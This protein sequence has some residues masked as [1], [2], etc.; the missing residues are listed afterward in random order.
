[1]HADVDP[2]HVKKC[3]GS[4]KE[5]IKSIN[6]KHEKLNYTRDDVLEKELQLVASCSYD[7]DTEWGEKVSQS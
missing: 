6:Y 2:I 1:M 4:S 3:F 7:D 5:F